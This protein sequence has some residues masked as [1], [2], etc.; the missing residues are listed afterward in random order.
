MRADL[1]DVGYNLIITLHHMVCPFV[2][3][4][5]YYMSL[6][7]N[8]FVWTYFTADTVF[9]FEP[10]AMPQ[11]TPPP[12]NKRK[13]IA[14]II[15]NLSHVTQDGKTSRKMNRERGKF[16]KTNSLLFKKKE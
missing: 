3:K 1:I 9:C 2:E 10:P 4:E 6:N 15:T 7:A 12:V 14:K 11:K 8:I 13:K 5:W 16:S